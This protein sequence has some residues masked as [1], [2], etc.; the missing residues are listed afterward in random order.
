MVIKSGNRVSVLPGVAE[1]LLSVWHRCFPTILL[2]S[3][4]TVRR[5]RSVP[6][7][8]EA[9]DQLRPFSDSTL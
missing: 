8:G 6:L 9:V 7:V 5:A 4:G 1:Q 3:Q 2:D